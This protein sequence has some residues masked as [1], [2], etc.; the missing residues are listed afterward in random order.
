MTDFVYEEAFSRNLGWV[1]AAEQQIL[2]G[3]RVAIA[4]M[5]GVGGSHLITM[6]RLGIGAFNIADFDT[7]EL[8]NF[9]RQAGAR[10][11]AIGKSKAET[12]DAMA[13]DINPE[14]DIKIFS[15][16]VT[17]ENLDE[18]LRDV[19]V[20]VDGLDFFV[21]DARRK[22]FARCHE[23]GIP[24]VT[25]APAG[26]GSAFLCFSPDGMSFEEWFRMEGLTKQQ[27]LVNFMIGL[28]P[29]GLHRSYLV[30]KSHMDFKGQ[31]LPS[32][33]L[34]CELSA[35]VATA[36]VLK[37]LLKRGPVY[38]APFYHH[39]DAYV[40]KWKL[41][42]MPGGNANPLQ[43]FK[44]KIAYKQVEQLSE[45]TIPRPLEYARDIEEIL[46]IARWAPSG[47]NV[48]PWRFEIIDDETVT[49][50]L[51][52]ERARDAEDFYDFND[53]QPTLI[54]GG[55][56]LENIRIAA[57]KFNRD[58]QWSL[59]GEDNGVYKI[60]VKVAKDSKV[61]TNPL[62][63]YIRIRS[64]DRNAYQKTPLTPEQK[65][66]LQ[67][68][69]GPDFEIAWYET[70]EERKAMSKI[71]MMGTDIR[72]RIPESF[73][74]HKHALDWKRNFSPAAIPIR[75]VGLDRMTSALMRWLFNDWKRIDFMNKFMAGTMIAQ[76]EMDLI[77]GT[78]CAAHFVLCAKDAKAPR[79]PEFFLRAGE[80]LQRLWLAATSHGLALHPST[81]T[82]MFAH[83]GR[84]K[85]SFTTNPKILAKA[86]TLANLLSEE[87]GK[88]PDE[89]TF[90]GRLGTP[91]F[92]PITARSIRLPLEELLIRR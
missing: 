7:F 87:T 77:P 16:G 59:M 64:V 13:K 44:L 81:A 54:A 21:L 30:D 90:M 65:T 39:F 27:Q 85:K 9:N 70:D 47:D 50:H 60:S 45:D 80:A 57:S 43:K 68:S 32:T 72:L 15:N 53:G 1:K 56:L 29:R 71:N 58:C 49:I 40:C 28:T 14:L 8:A 89:I 23:L 20:Y 78:S 86:E 76:I 46:N 74:T 83:F 73:N 37:L 62:L 2:R 18:F 82:H 11:S 79:S 22:V 52:T 34:A 88:E 24:S 51:L 19:D 4:G 6:T 42:W 3:K 26:M 66:A 75:A 38:A 35:G 12:L 36:Q 17:D 61:A 55:T 10:L 63:P 91:K 84:Q 5:G 48:Q 31:R 33:G 67:K 92:R 41:G 69:V 25:A